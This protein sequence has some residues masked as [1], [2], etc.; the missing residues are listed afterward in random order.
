MLATEAAELAD[1]LPD[2]E[3]RLEADEAADESD[4]ETDEAATSAAE[5]AEDAEELPS[6]R[7]QKTAHE[8]H[9]LST[10][11]GLVG[12]RNCTGTGDRGSG[13]GRTD[14]TDSGGRCRCVGSVKLLLGGELGRGQ[15][16]IVSPW[17]RG[18]F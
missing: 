4:D 12:G 16:L 1:G 15:K 7:I 8:I 11:G 17:H 6:V 13:A 18:L 10:D 5:E 9:S 3:A 2:L 14:G